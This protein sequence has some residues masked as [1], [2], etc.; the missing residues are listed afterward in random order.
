MN[1]TSL[2]NGIATVIKTNGNQEITGN[3]LKG[4]L[5]S[6]VNSLGANATFAGMAIPSTS[7]GTPDGPVFYLAIQAG[8]YPNFG[9]AN[10]QLSIGE[11]GIFKWDGTTWEA[12]KFISGNGGSDNHFYG[13]FSSSSNLPHNGNIGG[14]AYVGESLPF[15][16]YNATSNNS[17]LTWTDSGSTIDITQVEADNEDLVAINN[18]LKLKDRPT[19]VNQ[20]GYKILR[21]G[22]SLASQMTNVNTIYEVRYAFDLGGGTLTIPSGSILKFDGGKISNG[23]I[24]F[25]GNSCSVESPNFEECTFTGDIITGAVIEDKGFAIGNINGSNVLSWL[26]TQAANNSATLNLSRD[27]YVDSV[28]TQTEGFYVEYGFLQLSNKSFNINGNCHTI[29]DEHVYGVGAAIPIFLLMNCHDITVRNLYYEGLHNDN[30]NKTNYDTLGQ[31]NSGGGVLFW[32]NGD[33]DNFNVIDGRIRYGQKYVAYGCVSFV[34]MSDINNR[35]QG[36][37]NLCVKGLTNSTFEIDA[38]DCVHPLAVCKGSNIKAKVKFNYVS[39]GV[40]LYGVQ[41]AEVY[42]EGCH[43]TTPIMVL[44]KDVISYTDDTYSTRVFSNCNNIKAYVKWLDIEDTYTSYIWG[45]IFV[46]LAN[47]D[48]EGNNETAPQFAERTTPYK[49]DNIQLNIDGTPTN[50][51]AFDFVGPNC[52]EGTD[53]YAVELSGVSN[54]YILIDRQA[55]TSKIINLKLK[56]ANIYGLL[57]YINSNSTICLENSIIGSLSNRAENIIDIV[58]DSKSSIITAPDKYFR[59]NSLDIS[60]SYISDITSI[61][62]LPKRGFV[63]LTTSITMIYNSYYPLLGRSLNEGESCEIIFF[64]NTNSRLWLTLD[65]GGATNATQ[66]TVESKTFI[67]VIATKVDGIIYSLME[68]IRTPKYKGAQLSTLVNDTTNI[69]YDVLVETT[70]KTIIW[71]DGAN[72]RT[73]DGEIAGIAR[74]GTF[75]NVPIPTNVGFQYFCASGA[76]IDGGTTEKTNIVIY[77]TGSGW[78]DANGNAVVAKA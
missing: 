16:I 17:V 5:N 42:V 43:C 24:T 66:V 71:Y 62:K 68:R 61:S 53:V 19:A 7:P 58:L 70:G 20:K 21:K 26:V 48:I 45:D 64:N 34:S 50:G 72:M 3:A 32:L 22:V 63:L 27:Y 78:V 11:L 8:S 76:S 44:L 57:G 38:F 54:R 28:R 74:S 31:F 75:A 49:C 46:S 60:M 23:Q 47:Y 73:Y 12:Q 69:I 1:W 59:I 65:A 39:R 35:I 13:Y 33:T 4:V 52:S 36:K 55:S 29:Y 51:F 41:N 15:A 9:S 56:N 77:Y 18:K 37:D 6:M 2:K 40:A 25:S 14:Y 67:K 30:N 10:F